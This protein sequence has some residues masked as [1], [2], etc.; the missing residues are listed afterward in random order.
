[1]RKVI[2]FVEDDENINT[3]ID[4]TLKKNGFQ[5]HGFLE[6]KTFLKN[7]EILRPDLIIL[8]LMLP[9]INGYELLKMIKS[10]KN[11]EDIPVIILSAKSSEIDI[12]RGLDMGASDYIVKPFGLLEFISRINVNLRKVSMSKD[13]V[14]SIRNLSLNLLKHKIYYKDQEIEFTTKEF[15]V[16]ELLMESPSIVVTRQ[17]LLK[18]V[19]GY[20][21]LVETRTLDMHIK[22]IREKINAY[23]DEIY[24]ETI[25]GL[26]YII[27]EE[28][29]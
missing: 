22:S 7:L 11:Y 27:N 15:D 13:K 16:M 12:V 10:N 21:F 26:G 18:K 25:R 24:I 19:W 5:S 3:L 8:D 9:I 6:G 23:T 2:Y 14:L 28:I 17:T 1:M 20:D 4:E 29:I